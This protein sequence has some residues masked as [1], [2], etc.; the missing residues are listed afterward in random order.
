MA[1]VFFSMAGVSGCYGVAIA[2]LCRR[3]GV[4]NRAFYQTF[5]GKEECFVLGFDLLTTPILERAQAAF[6]GTE[7]PWEQRLG[8]GL[9]EIMTALA[10][11][12][13]AARSCA[14]E[15]LGA[16]PDAL[17]HLRAVILRTQVMFGCAPRGVTLPVLGGDPLCSMLVGA[18]LQPMQG[19]LRADR[20]DRLP[21]L[22]PGFVSLLTRV[23]GDQA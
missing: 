16:G 4:S 11:D 7:G 18:I 23:G 6:E 22:V 9:R 21:E 12:P 15:V 17:E 13:L 8:A 1:S 19:Y 20:A 10:A 5:S 14:L 3:V 2:D